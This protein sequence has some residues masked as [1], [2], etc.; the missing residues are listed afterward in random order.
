[1]HASPRGPASLGHRACSH[2]VVLSK[3]DTKAPPQL[4]AQERLV[5]TV[6]LAFVLPVRGQFKDLADVWIYVGGGFL[7]FVS[8]LFSRCLSLSFKCNL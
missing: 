6:T 7:G 8:F 5:K 2:Q 1:M 3:Q 4:S